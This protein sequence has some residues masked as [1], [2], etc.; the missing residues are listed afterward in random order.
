MKTIKIFTYISFLTFILGCS[1]NNDSNNDPS[2]DPSGVPL[3]PTNLTGQAD[4]IYQ[5]YIHLSWNDNSNNETEFKIERKTGSENYVEIGTTMAD[6]TFYN[7][8]ST[9]LG[10]TYTYRVRSS[11]TFGNSITYSNEFSAT[12]LTVISLPTL[13]LTSPSAITDTSFLSGGNISSDGGAP[14]TARGVCWSSTTMQPTIDLATKTTDGAGIGVF[15]SN[16]SG[17]NALTNYYVRPYATNSAGTSYGNGVAIITTLNNS[18]TFTTIQICNQNWTKA[19]LYTTNYRNGDAIPLVT[20]PLVWDSLTTGAYTYSNSDPSGGT[21]GFYYNWYAVNDPRGLAPVGYHIPSENEWIT[22][23]N[24]LGGSAVAGGKMK[25]E[26]LYWAIGIT[27]DPNT[28]D[29]G[30]RGLPADEAWG[31]IGYNAYW[32]SSSSSSSSS[33]RSCNLHYLSRNAQIAGNSK[34]KGLSIRL[35]KD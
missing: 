3:A 6:D 28:Y 21:Y 32:W 23:I 10:T 19:N 16:I 31:A 4:P 5:H 8:S 14:I 34:R 18:Y 27:P 2:N 25:G 22:L 12:T 13:T 9:T 11:N 29:S 26:P 7:D 1:P 30:F 20:D 35:I 15:T 24:C 33:A 17:L